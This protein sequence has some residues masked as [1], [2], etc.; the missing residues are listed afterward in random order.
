MTTFLVYTGY[1]V[2]SWLVLHTWSD[3]LNPSDP[4]YRHSK[5]A[6]QWTTMAILVLAFVPGILIL[7]TLRWFWRRLDVWS[8]E[9]G[10]S[11]PGG[12]K[13]TRPEPEPVCSCIVVHAGTDD[14][15]LYY[16]ES[17]PVH[18]EDYKAWLAEER[19]RLA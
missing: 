19:R 5:G 18:G 15:Y 10:Y 11:T 6:P 12:T 2:I 17:C 9:R 13:A 7:L 1:F 8:V 14:A 4:F 16:R 3:L